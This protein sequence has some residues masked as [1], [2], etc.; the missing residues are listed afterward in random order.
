M[1]WNG[2][3]NRERWIHGMEPCLA[4]DGSRG[5]I[6]SMDFPGTPKDL[7]KAQKFTGAPR[8]ADGDRDASRADL[9]RGDSGAQARGSSSDSPQLKRLPDSPTLFVQLPSVPSLS[10]RLPPPVPSF[11]K[12][13]VTLRAR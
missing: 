7:G 1:R 5:W 8:E 9:P 10:V 2:I 11:D 13:R 3:L 4:T 12:R 6:H